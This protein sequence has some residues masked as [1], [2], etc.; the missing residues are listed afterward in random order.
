[1][2]KGLSVLLKS[3]AVVIGWALTPVIGEYLIDDTSQLS[4]YQLAFFRYFLAAIALYFILIFQQKVKNK[5][6]IYSLKNKWP[7]YILISVM[8]AFMPVLL[9]LAVEN[10][11]AS[12]ASFLLNSNVILIP[13]F[14]IIILKEK[15]RKNYVVG[16]AISTIGLFLVIFDENLLALADLSFDAV[17]GNLLGF[18]SGFFWALYT[19]FLKKFFADENPILVTF[20]S[21]LM[22]SFY[23]V[24]FAFAIPPYVNMTFDIL[25]II[26]V[27]VIAVLS[28]SLAYSYWLSL[29]KVLPTTQTGIIQSFVPMTS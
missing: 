7:K 18:G 11:T 28:T 22:G 12:S 4:P 29:L 24:F 5:E 10:T 9:F 20:I 17:I 3:S 25:G 6:I 16:I 26:L 21:L 19:V 27:I 23:L 1:M 14:A 13:I 15:I 2:K 8:S